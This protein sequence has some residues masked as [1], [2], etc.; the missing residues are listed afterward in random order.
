MCTDRYITF[1]NLLLLVLAGCTQ[2]TSSGIP[3]A[4]NTDA[5]LQTA[6]S[7]Q[8]ITLAGPS[9]GE[10]R[11]PDSVE[12]ERRFRAA[13]SSG[14]SGQLLAAYRRQVEHTI[15]NMGGD[16]HGRGISGTA[17]DVH[18]FSYSYAWHRNKGII[19]V[20]SFPTTNGTVDAVLF[21]YEHR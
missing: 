11:D 8:G 13:I 10:G 15:T 3:Q 12:T 1:F 2:M 21:C 6:G 18:D 9:S 16:I 4:L 5:L 19:R 17:D 7:S 20:Y 14:T